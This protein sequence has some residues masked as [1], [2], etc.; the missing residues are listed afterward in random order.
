MPIE[1]ISN[2][3]MRNK[4]EVGFLSKKANFSATDITQRYRSEEWLAGNT[5]L[6]FFF[7]DQPALTQKRGESTFLKPLTL[8]KYM[9][10]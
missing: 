9:F 5:F 7:H 10:Q 3:N 8:Q 2:G 4:K 1:P 6:T